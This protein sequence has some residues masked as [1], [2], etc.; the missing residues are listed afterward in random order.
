[1]L[2]GQAKSVVAGGSLGGTNGSRG[3]ARP[4][5]KQEG[6]GYAALGAESG[7]LYVASVVPGGAA[8]RAGI[9]A[10][11]RLLSLDGNEVPSFLLF[12]L[13]L[14]E[15]KER[16]FHLSWRSGGHIRSAEMRQTASEVRDGLGEGRAR[17][18]RCISTS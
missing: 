14:Q 15:I 3:N 1:M 4:I 9:R 5:P 7:E 8:E 10:G 13:R 12:S 17:L 11:D 2:D 16:P 6:T 18:G